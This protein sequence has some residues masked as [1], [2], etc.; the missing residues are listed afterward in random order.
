MAQTLEQVINTLDE[1]AFILSVAYGRAVMKKN[2]EAKR[3]AS[4]GGRKLA[5]RAVALAHEAKLA[6]VR[7]KKKGQYPEMCYLGSTDR[8]WRAYQALRRLLNSFVGWADVPAY[9]I[10]RGVAWPHG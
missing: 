10:R 4:W 8:E 3:R 6:S 9:G 5:A 7:W 2:T 1:R